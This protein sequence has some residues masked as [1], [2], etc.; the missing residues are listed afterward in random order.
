MSYKAGF[1]SDSNS[2][3]VAAAIATMLALALAGC[4]DTAAQHAAPVRPVMVS[5]WS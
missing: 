4:D 1:S 5:E 2:L 3:R